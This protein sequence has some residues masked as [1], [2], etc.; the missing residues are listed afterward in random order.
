MLTEFMPN[1]ASNGIALNNFV[2]NMFS[3]VGAIVAAP[4]I[5]AIGN[6]W[7]GT[8]FGLVTLISGIV[9]IWS[10]RRFG[11]SWRVR[12]EREID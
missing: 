1:H 7:L 11:P 6:G 12:M 3:C 8:I 2:R 10:M 4:L 9:T 5:G